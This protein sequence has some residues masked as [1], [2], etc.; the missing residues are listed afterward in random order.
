[1]LDVIKEFNSLVQLLCNSLSSCTY[2]HS[3]LLLMCT[4][5]PSSIFIFRNTYTTD[6]MNGRNLSLSVL[7]LEIFKVRT[8]FTL[9]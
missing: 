2:N 6:A 9:I 5:S 4:F 3:Q 1:M 8:N 7:F